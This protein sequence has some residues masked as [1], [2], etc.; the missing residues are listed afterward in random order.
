[1][2]GGVPL[3]AGVCFFL[4]LHPVM[5]GDRHIGISFRLRSF[6]DAFLCVL[7]SLSRL[8]FL[9]LFG[10]SLRMVEVTGT[11]GSLHGMVSLWILFFAW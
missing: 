6:L 7:G 5:E 11:A 10:S 1:L 3:S 2:N 9:D 4:D 8:V